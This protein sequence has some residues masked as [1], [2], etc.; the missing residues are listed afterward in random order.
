[1][2]QKIGK[3]GLI[4]SIVIILVLLLRFGIEKGVKKNWDTAKDVKELI[5]YFIL[6]LTV[7]VV[8]IP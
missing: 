4:S 3:F 2:A 8:A 1:M 6:G 7:I 5:G